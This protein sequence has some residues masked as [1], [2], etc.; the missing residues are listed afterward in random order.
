MKRNGSLG[1]ILCL[2]SFIC[3]AQENYEIQVYASPTMTKGFSMVELHSNFTF[4]G[5]KSII[6]KVRPSF[7]SLH[8]TL[9]ITNG[10]TKN[11]ELGFYLFTNYTSPYGYQVVGAH[12]RPRVCVPE[13]WHWPFGASLSA[14]FGYQKADYS[15]QTWNIELRP[16]IDKQFNHF[17]LGFNPVFGISLKGTDN[18]HTPSFEPNVKT[19]WTFNKVALGFEY[20]GDMGPVNNMPSL[21]Q[22]GHT[23]FAA[24][25]LY[26]DPRWEFNIGPGW[27]LT[28]ATDGF[29]FKILVGRRFPWHPKKET[30]KNTASLGLFT[31]GHPSSRHS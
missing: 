7:H 13:E 28:P 27:G 6:D 2:C 11:F 17:Y 12:I 15:D 26:I 30:E 3:F 14:E 25:D 4:D 31:A 8:E 29:I 23:L 16:I 18:S 10:L 24:A 21:S 1:A 20:Y 5:E 9:E 19:S 22:Q